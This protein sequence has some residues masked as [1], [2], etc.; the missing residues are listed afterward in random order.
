MYQFLRLSIAKEPDGLSMSFLYLLPA[1]F[2]ALAAAYRLAK[3]NVDS[4]Q[5]YGFKGVPTPAAG[6]LIASF[7]LIYWFDVDS[8]FTGLLLNKWFLYGII[9]LI[10]W[11]MVS[12]IPM[13]AFKFRNLSIKSNIPKILLLLITV[14]SIFLF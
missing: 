9:L 11:L 3:F 6:L 7:P 5:Q 12:N 13:M 8:V 10:C 14:I 4:S 2:I 1:L